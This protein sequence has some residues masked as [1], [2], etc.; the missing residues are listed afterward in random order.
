[1]ASFML[2]VCSFNFFS[3]YGGFIFFVIFWSLV[4]A[5]LFFPAIMMTVGP[6]SN[7][8]DINFIR[9]LQGHH[10]RPRSE[11]S[12]SSA[13]SSTPV[14]CAMV[15]LVGAP[16]DDTDDVSR[17]GALPE[18]TQSVGGGAAGDLELVDMEGETVQ[19]GA[20]ELE[21]AMVT[22]P[23]PDGKPCAPEHPGGGGR[24]G[25]EP[26]GAQGGGSVGGEPPRGT[27]DGEEGGKD[28]LN[29][30]GGGNNGSNIWAVISEP[31]QAA[32]C[33]NGSSAAADIK[34]AK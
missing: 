16:T 2:F 28:T 32:D 33:L 24:V 25:G 34:P 15:G 31:F 11:S 18:K 22:F 29:G 30:N 5:M 12:A 19:V 10:E 17:E 9:K 4:W 6:C 20:D 7:R 23:K 1:M 13:D 8:G 14:P 21:R 27:S 3:T 26:Q